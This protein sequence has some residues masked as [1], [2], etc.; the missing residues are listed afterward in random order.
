MNR[1]LIVSG[2]CIILAVLSLVLWNHLHDKG[3]SLTY[4]RQNPVSTQKEGTN[5]LTTSNI[6]I[7]NKPITSV[8]ADNAELMVVTVDAE[9]GQY[10]STSTQRETVF[11][12]DKMGHLIWSNNLAEKLVSEDGTKRI[13]SIKSDGK[14]VFVAIGRSS[15]ALSLKDGKVQ[16][17]RSY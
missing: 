11:L 14:N 8:N 13:S 15:V 10:V 16:D 1:F 5:V 7:T 6:E 17:F 2:S 12:K 4:Q 9:S 3:G